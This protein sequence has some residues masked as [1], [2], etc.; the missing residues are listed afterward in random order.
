MFYYSD[1]KPIFG[2]FFIPGIGAGAGTG[3]G[4]ET[5]RKITVPVLIAAK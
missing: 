5:S 4:A 3:T 1:P 2:T